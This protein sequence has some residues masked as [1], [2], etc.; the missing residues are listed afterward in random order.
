M[1]YSILV[2]WAC[3]LFLGYDD[4]IRG[5]YDDVIRWHILLLA[6]SLDN[7][8]IRLTSPPWKTEPMALTKL[9]VFG[10][11]KT[12]DFAP[13]SHQSRKSFTKEILIMQYK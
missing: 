9:W 10:L 8:R 12:K 6:I 4:I 1:F 7:I 11:L 5:S 3:F 2:V 13:P